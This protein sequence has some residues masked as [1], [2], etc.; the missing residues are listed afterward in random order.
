MLL[1]A[2]V[3]GPIE[4]NTYVVGDRVA[5]EV[6]VVDPGGDPSEILDWLRA[7]RLRVKYIINTHGHFDHVGGNRVLKAAT[8]ATILAHAAD[9]PMLAEADRQARKYLLHSENSP[10]PDLYLEDREEVRVGSVVLRVL[11][12]PGHSPG[13][14]VLVGQG[15]V[16]C[17]DLVFHGSVGRT[18]LPGGSE[19]QLLA[20]IRS[21]I[22]TLPDDTVIHPGHGPE[23]TVG[24]EKRQNP[25]FR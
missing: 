16:L 14:I 24:L 11:H 19:E 18:D 15:V 17:G 1:H 25:F 3:T 5:G 4:T 22:L 6:A 7:E 13:G 2:F 20:S 8:G 21:A 10:P 23:T 12:T 9:A